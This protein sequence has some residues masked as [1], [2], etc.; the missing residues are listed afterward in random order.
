MYPLSL[1]SHPIPS[2]R[3]AVALPSFTP[4]FSSTP[5]DRPPP[6]DP[7]NSHLILAVYRVA[8]TG[9][10]HQHKMEDTTGGAAA[11]YVPIYPLIVFLG[12][13]NVRRRLFSVERERGSD[14]VGVRYQELHRRHH[15]QDRI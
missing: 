7:F 15:C 11:W 10:A 5:L 2:L 14:I 13:C 9:K 3:Y 12:A 4:S 8:D 6:R 1:S